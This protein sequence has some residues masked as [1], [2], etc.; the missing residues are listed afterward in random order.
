[1]PPVAY[2]KFRA[3]RCL[4]LM[5][6]WLGRPVLPMPIAGRQRLDTDPGFQDDGDRAHKARS[7]FRRQRAL[8]DAG[9]DRRSRQLVR[10]R[11]GARRP[12]LRQGARGGRGGDTLTRAGRGFRHSRASSRGRRVASQFELR[13]PTPLRPS[14]AATGSSEKCQERSFGEGQWAPSNTRSRAAALRK[15]LSGAS[16]TLLEM[17]ALRCA[18]S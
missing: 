17:S 2:D 18:G 14:N 5:V 9:H 13:L 3:L 8:Q 6:R 1:M 7:E 10:D 11:G 15:K 4:T 12:R 16:T